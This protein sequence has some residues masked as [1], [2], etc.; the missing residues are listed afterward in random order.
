M[1]TIN[2]CQVDISCNLLSQDAIAS[3]AYEKSPYPLEP[4]L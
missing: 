2:L 1:R 3:K 4:E